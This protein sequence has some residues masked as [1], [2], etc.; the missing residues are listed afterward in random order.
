MNSSTNLPIYYSKQNLTTWYVDVL[1]FYFLPSICLFGIVTSLVCILVSQNRDESNAKSL[2]YIWINSII[3]F[4]FLLLEIFIAIVKCGTLCPYGY[5][6]AAKFYE[7]YFYLYVGYILVTAQMLLNIQVSYERL[8]M[9]SGKLTAAKKLTIFQVFAICM[10]ISTLANALPYPISRE[11]ALFGIYKP[12]PNSTYFE[13]LY[14]RAYRAEFLTPAMQNFMTAVYVVKNLVVFF[15]LSV[16]SILVCVRFRTYLNSRKH[17][18][19][20]FV[21][22]EFLFLMENKFK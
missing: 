3:D 5:S 14:K 1:N 17:L 10:F 21:L 13:Y 8:K 22:C 9:F 7:V 18:V 20:R 11:V 19:K 16:L 2:E 15:V 4:V 12:D 6:Y